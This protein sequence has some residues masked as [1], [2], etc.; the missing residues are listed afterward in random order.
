MHGREHFAFRQHRVLGACLE[1]ALRSIRSTERALRSRGCFRS[2]AR[3]LRIA[4]GV[5]H[6]T[7]AFR[8]ARTSWNPRRIDGREKAVL[9]KGKKTGA[10]AYSY[11][12]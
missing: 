7:R 4:H 3:A 11:Y 9:S 2:T 12:S 8:H 1:R 10:L 5:S 6:N